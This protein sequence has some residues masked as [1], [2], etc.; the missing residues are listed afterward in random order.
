MHSI[1]YFTKWFCFPLS[2]PVVFDFQFPLIDNPGNFCWFGQTLII[3]KVA[4]DKQSF[5]A[6]KVADGQD[7]PSPFHET[8]DHILALAASHVLDPRPILKDFLNYFVEED[9]GIVFEDSMEVRIQKRQAAKDRLEAR[10]RNYMTQQLMEELLTM[11][12]L[13]NLNILDHIVFIQ[14]A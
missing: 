12:Q 1:L 14:L 3:L 6:K 5:L 11:Q 4:V 9:H 7:F 13:P 2:A 8:F 10:K